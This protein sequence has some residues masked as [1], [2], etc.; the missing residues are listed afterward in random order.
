MRNHLWF[1][2]T[3]GFNTIQ[4][5]VFKARTV[6][7]INYNNIILEA[8]KPE[9]NVT[10]IHSDYNMFATSAISGIVKTALA[11][12]DN[13]ENICQNIT[14]GVEDIYKK[15]YK[16]FCSIITFANIDKIRYLA[17]N[18]TIFLMRI[19]NLN[20]TIFQMKNSLDPV[21]NN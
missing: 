21:K 8:R 12:L 14:N 10:I 1:Q 9:A 4:F 17:K 2:H 6:F 11:K 16:Y 20:F 19:G 15:Q 13:L 7:P 5:M 18:N 3:S